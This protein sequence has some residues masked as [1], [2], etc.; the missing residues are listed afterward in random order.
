M[1][2][3]GELYG[4]WGGDGGGEDGGGGGAE[5]EQCCWEEDWG[6]GHSGGDLSG[7]TNCIAKDLSM[8]T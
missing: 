5:R 7:W 1:W 2:G 6:N 8:Y 4:E 3:R